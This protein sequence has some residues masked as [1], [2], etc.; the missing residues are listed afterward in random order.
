APPAP[1]PVSA[2][3]PPARPRQAAPSPAPKPAA[4]SYQ[5]SN[6][7]PLPAYGSANT[8][9]VRHAPPPAKPTSIDDT[10]IQEL[11]VSLDESHASK[12]AAKA[13]PSL[14]DEMTKLLGELASQKR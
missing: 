11:E 14:D 1:Q 9:A 13:P 3:P 10:L 7:T 4:P 6:I 8:N 2:T 12:P 5:A